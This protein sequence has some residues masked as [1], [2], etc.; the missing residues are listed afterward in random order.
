MGPFRLISRG[1]QVPAFAF[2]TAAD[3]HTF[4]VFDVSRRLRERGWLVPAYPFPANRTDL[5]VLRIVVRNGFTQDL[6][7]LLLNDLRR[8]VPQ[9]QAQSTPMRRASDDTGFHH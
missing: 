5:S 2:T 6:A 1:D 7:E 9:L 4:D 8:L 3:V